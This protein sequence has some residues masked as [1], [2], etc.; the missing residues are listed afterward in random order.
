MRRWIWGF[1]IRGLYQNN[2]LHKR[3]TLTSKDNLMCSILNHALQSLS[4][5]LKNY[6][7]NANFSS[8]VFAHTFVSFEGPSRVLLLHYTT[9]S[10]QASK[11]INLEV[12]R[13]YYQISYQVWHHELKFES[14]CICVQ[15]S[16]FCIQLKKQLFLSWEIHFF[17]TVEPA[18]EQ[19]CVP[20]SGCPVS[21]Q[22]IRYEHRLGRLRSRKGFCWTPFSSGRS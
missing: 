15:Q 18:T 1:F 4:L 13:W 10:M 20:H 19:E 3:Q 11:L 6:L 7:A 21:P 22:F 17:I 9:I 5:G 16:L 2:Q 12:S 14:L 8:G